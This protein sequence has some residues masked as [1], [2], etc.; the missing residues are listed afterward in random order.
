MQVALYARVSST[1]HTQTIDQQLTRLQAH[2]HEHGWTLQERHIYRDDG[3]SGASLTRPGLDALR[4]RVA[5]AEI[6]LLLVTAPDR[7]ARNARPLGA[8]HRGTATRWGSSRISGASHEP[9]SSRSVAPA[10]SWGG[11]RV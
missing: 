4:D 2:V 11:G 9:G 3:Y 10:D 1:R 6:D 8:P 5:L 7:L